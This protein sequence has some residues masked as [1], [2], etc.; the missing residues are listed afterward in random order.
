MPRHGVVSVPFPTIYG[1][2]DRGLWSIMKKVLIFVLVV[3]SVASSGFACDSCSSMPVF[4]EG[5]TPGQTSIGIYGQYNKI[6]NPSSH[7]KITEYDLQTVLSH[8]LSERWSATV[9]IPYLHKT[10]D[11][12]P[13]EDGIG[14]CSL[15]AVFHAL[16]SSGLQANIFAG[17]TVPTGDTD[18][19]EEERE[20]YLENLEHGEGEDHHHAHGHHLALG[21]GSVDALLGG[22]LLYTKD[23]WTGTAQAQY[24]LTTEGDYVFEY[25][26][27]IQAQA[28]L[29]Y[30]VLRGAT[31][32]TAIGIDTSISWQDNNQVMGVEQEGGNDTIVYAGPT[33][34]YKRVNGLKASFG[35][36]FAVSDG[37]EGLDGAADKRCWANLAC[38]F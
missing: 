4:P 1:P 2:I 36:D 22:S 17:I 30:A 19:L 8:G 32:S 31:S 18:P 33:A 14:D 37:G 21:S 29:E 16:R 24:R 28:G 3:I 13:T 11:D 27:S 7:H 12:E 9:V 5:G 20:V 6:D 25:G 15:E 35:W 26:D 23:A 10:L 38:V 34:S